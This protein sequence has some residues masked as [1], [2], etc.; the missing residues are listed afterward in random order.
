MNL[1]TSIRTPDFWAS[2]A[3]VACA[4]HCLATP[5]LVLAAPALGVTH[6]FDW[7]IWAGSG[8]LSAVLLFWSVPAH[9]R[10]IVWL[11][12]FLG[13]V[14]WALGLFELL[15]PLPE[16]LGKAAG[17]VLLAAGVAWNGR[18]RHQAVCEECACPVHAQ[19]GEGEEPAE[20]VY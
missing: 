11:P 4:V 2:A 16:S 14:V 7:W 5:V 9:G 20:V 15:A 12:V 18:L 19:Q 1:S 3:P 13:L 8:L 6:A 17:A 10:R